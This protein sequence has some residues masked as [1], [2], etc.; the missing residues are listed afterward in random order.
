[1]DQL[2]DVLTVDG[3]MLRG[4]F[5]AYP[6]TRKALRVVTITARLAGI[7]PELTEIYGLGPGNNFH[8]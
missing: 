6:V 5:D 8:S 4:T 7:E 1:M 2:F 3:R